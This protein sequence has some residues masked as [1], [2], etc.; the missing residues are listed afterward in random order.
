M[1]TTYSTPLPGVT[2]EALFAWHARPSAF[3]RLNPPWD[4][5]RVV[6][7][8]GPAGLDVGVELEL[9][10]RVGPAEVSWL[11]R[12]VACT[13]PTG[14][15][16]EQQRGPFARWR[17]EHRFADGA[18]TDAIEWEV[19][20]GAAGRLVAG[21]AIQRRLDRVFAFRHR[22][23][24]DDLGLWARW[25]D[26]R[27]LRVAITGA[28]GFLGGAL[29]SVLDIGGDEVVPV[30][31]RGAA[32]S[33]LGLGAFDGVDAV[34]H[35]AGEPL[36]GR[37]WTEAHKAAVLASRRVGTEAVVASLIDAQARDP[38]PDRVLV[39]ASAIGWYG[40][41]G[42][43]LM[44]EDSPR[45]DGFLAEVCAAWEAATEPARDAGIRVV[46]ARIGLVLGARGG[47]LGALLP[48][49]RA[50]LGGPQGDGQAWQSVIA[51]DDAVAALVFAIREPS[52]RG[53]VNLVGP[54][55]LRQ[56]DLARAIGRAVGRPA[57]TPTPRLALAAA[58][59]A[60]AADALVLASQR[61]APDALV[62]AGFGF[63]YP[64]A[65]AALGHQLGRTPLAT[66][67]QGA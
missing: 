14:F 67:A 64:D 20:L 45:G 29:G 51:I 1:I 7:R 46:N 40:D 56:R 37:R 2:A 9:A 43:A 33:G 25:P 41:R 31:T 4:P 63:R 49:Y 66:P 60:E 47:L 54:N 13:P 34:V 48:L 39:S 53:P 22:R 38:R 32:A 11:T 21:A 59:G 58:V 42:D 50:G 44:H 65:D 23:T 18:L 8:S 61:V 62:A 15:V 19:P 36:A 6:R 30:S 55:P 26:R 5:V 27:R 52:L 28:T 57:I 16:D 10:A 12:H 24:A 35:L 17:H 3:E